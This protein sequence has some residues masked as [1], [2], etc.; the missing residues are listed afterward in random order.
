MNTK[1]QADHKHNHVIEQLEKLGSYDNQAYTYDELERKLAAA[2]AMEVQIDV[3]E[4][5]YF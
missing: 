4:N 1:T 5:K 3:V 2:R